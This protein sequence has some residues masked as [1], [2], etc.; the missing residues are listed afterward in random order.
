[1]G[2]QRRIDLAILFA[3]REVARTK[4]RVR[5][6]LLLMDEIIDS[7]LDE[8]GIDNFF[9][10]IEEV[11]SDTNVFIISPRGQSFA[12]KFEQV[13]TFEYDGNYNGMRKLT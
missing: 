3:W 6:N 13:L 1:M 5:T 10:I 9:K 7:S 12:D 11:S 8:L 2:Q 4:A